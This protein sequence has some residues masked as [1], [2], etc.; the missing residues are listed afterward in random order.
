MDNAVVCCHAVVSQKG[1]IAI[2]GKRMRGDGNALVLIA[3]C[4]SKIFATNLWIADTSKQV[5]DRL[6]MSLTKDVV[7][8]GPQWRPDHAPCRVFSA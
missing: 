3:P 4:R 5:G 1:D 7:V 8:T 6:A 2:A